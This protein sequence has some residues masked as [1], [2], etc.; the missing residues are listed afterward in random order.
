MNNKKEEKLDY[1]AMI[2]KI[3]TFVIIIGL[4]GVSFVVEYIFINKSK[5]AHEFCENIGGLI[6]KKGSYDR[7]KC[8]NNTIYKLTTSKVKGPSIDKWGDFDTGCVI[9]CDREFYY[10]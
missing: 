1:I 9:F 6:D 7:I 3:I 2:L 4:L 10:K 5:M 8:G